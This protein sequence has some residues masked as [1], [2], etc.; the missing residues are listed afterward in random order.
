LAV[1]GRRRP[2][3]SAAL[4]FAFVYA[5]LLAVSATALAAF[6]W[7]ATA[8][9]LERQTDT[10]I[11]ADAEALLDRFEQGGTA[12][13]ILTIRDR[14]EQDVD[15]SSIY[16]FVTP[17][18]RLLAGNLSEWPT[19]VHT[20]E[21]FYELPVERAGVRYLA[22][23]HRYDLPGEYHL[24]V[25]RDMETRAQLRRLLSNALL[26]AMVVVIGLATLGGFVVRGLFRRALADVSATASAI[27]ARR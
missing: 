23:V 17:D 24:L 21:R 16:L 2:L 6:L 25:G 13:V 12:A 9:L 4:R 19:A 7:W 14:L 26:W 5:L 3:R 15:D 8:G 22:R 18:G 27:G 20:T 11:T 1:F 10:I